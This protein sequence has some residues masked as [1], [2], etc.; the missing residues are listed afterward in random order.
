MTIDAHHSLVGPADIARLDDVHELLDAVWRDAPHIG[1]SER[2]RFTLI[3]AELVA[4]VIE[5]GATGQPDPPSLELTIEI[6]GGAITG[7]LRDDGAPPPRGAADGPR[8]TT[9]PASF[10]GPHETTT[11]HPHDPTALRESGRGLLLVRTVAD[12]LALT[13][14]G[15]HN[16]WHF[17]VRARAAR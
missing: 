13:R 4:N 2:A 6:R 10:H 14:Q 15:G 11:T 7:T 5:H 3:V 8:L 1:S 12:D 16:H 17:T 9:P